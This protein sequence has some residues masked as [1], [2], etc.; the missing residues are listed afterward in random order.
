MNKLKLLTLF[1]AS[2]SLLTLVSCDKDDDQ[3]LSKTEML[4]GGE[5]TG[6]Q[7]YSGGVNVTTQ[8]EA[9]LESDIS[10]AK[11]NFAK[12]GSYTIKFDG[13][14]ISSGDWQFG[15]SEKT[16][17]LDEGTEDENTYT[18]N[19]L[20]PSDLYLE[21]DLPVDEEGFMTIEGEIRLKR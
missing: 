13:N 17:V 15:S 8:V 16:I 7:V 6:N 18:V 21:G 20:T 12:D 5:W 4:T 9:L 10:S 11:F 14:T 19:K 3:D 1:F 2:L